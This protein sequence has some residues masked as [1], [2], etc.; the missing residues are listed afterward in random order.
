[1]ILGW[2]V[3]VSCG[4]DLRLRRIGAASARACVFFHENAPKTNEKSKMRV[5]DSSSCFMDSS[6]SLVPHV[7]RNA[8]TPGW[9]RLDLIFLNF[10]LAKTLRT[11]QLETPTAI[12]KINA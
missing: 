3:C 6:S 10:S 11:S 12:A 4:R 1:M 8:K 7:P 9:I 5:T 2:V